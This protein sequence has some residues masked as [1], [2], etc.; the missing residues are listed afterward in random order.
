MGCRLIWETNLYFML[1]SFILPLPHLMFHTT[2]QLP[3]FLQFTCSDEA[4]NYTNNTTFK[5]NLDTVL[6]SI[7]SKTSYIDYGYYN[8]TA[9][10]E[11]DRATALAL[12]RG[13]VE[14]EQCRRCV[15]NSTLRIT[16]DCPNQKE[17]EGLYQDCQIRYSNNS[18]YGVKDNTVQLFLVNG[19]RVEDW[20]GFNMALRSLFDRLKM[21]ASS[22]SSIQKSAWG[23]EKVRSPSMDTIYGLVDCFP[24]LSYLDCFDC[25]NQL[26]A[27]LPSCCNASIG[28][29]LAATSCQ[30]AYEL[31]PVYAP[32]P[33][34]PSPL[35]LSPSPS[36]ENNDNSGRSRTTFVIIMVTI[37]SA[38]VILLVVIFT[39]LILRKKK[40]KR[41]SDNFEG[42]GNE[43]ISVETIQFDFDSIKVATND[44][45]SEN[46][47]GQ[48]GFGV[49]YKGKLP[50]GR[51]IAVKRLASSSQQGDV[52]FKNEVLLMLKLQ[53][54]NLVRLLGFCL[55]GSE[56][57]LIYEF[58]QN[59]SLDHFIFDSAKR[60]LLDWET[61]C[62][63]INGIARGLVYLHEDSQHRI[64]HR[65]LKA[66]NI[67]LDED[68]NSKISDFGMARLFEVDQTQGNTNRVV[69]TYGYMAPEYVIHG[70]FSVKSDVYSFGILVLEILSG[71][72]NNSFHNKELSE[73]L[74]SFAWTNWMA[75]TI[76]NII[77]STLTVG[78][79]I[80][81]IRCIHIGLLC[82]QE[83]L[84]NRP[85]M[86][87]VVM[88]L[89]T[90][91][92]TLPM[93]SKPAF[94]LHSSTNRYNGT[95]ARP[96]GANCENAS[97][98]LSKNY[99][100]ITEVKVIEMGSLCCE[101][102]FFL[103][104]FILLL[105][106]QHSMF[107]TTNSQPDFI[108]SS[109]S[110][111]AIYTNNSPFKKNLHNV[112]FSISSQTTLLDYGRFYNATS[113]EDPDRAT[114][115]AL[116]RGGVPLE[117]C[118]SCVYNST[119]RITK[120]CPKQREAEGWYSDCQI[121]YSNNSIYGVLVRNIKY[122]VW[123]RRTAVNPDGF[124]KVLRSLL[125]ELGREAASGSSVQKSA[126]GD[127]KVPSSSVDIIYGLVDCLPDL[128][129]LDCL[130]CLHMLQK[131][132]PTCCNNSM[133]VR[134][135]GISCQ[136]NY[137]SKPIYPSL[138]S[139]PSLPP[140]P[141]P[142]SPPTPVISGSTGRS[143]SSVV[144]VVVAVVPTVIL[145]VAIFIILILRKRK[146]KRPLDNFER[147]SLEDTTDEI[148]CVEMIQFDLDSIKAATNNFAS[149]NKL[150]QGGFG[151]VY[152][153]RLAV[154]RPIAVKR[155][156]NNSQQ[157]DAEFKN[158]VLLVLK[159]QH[160][161]LVRLLGFCLQGSERLL[162]YEFIP[163]GSLDNFIFDPQK[164]TQLNWERRYKII[165]GIARGLLYLHE[166][167]RFRIIH[168]D[169]KASNILLDQEMNPKIGDFGM[170]RLF[171]VDQ[172]RG[173]TNR[174]VGTFGYMAP[175][176]VKHGHFSVK[177]DVFSFGILV[178]EILSGKKNNNSHNGEHSEDLSSFVWTN[179]RAGTTTNV[180][181]S[182]L[183]VG[184]RMDME[185]CIHIGLLC[186]Q[187]NLVD[188]PTMNSIV[189]MLSS[190]TLTL[191]I[192]HK[193][194]FFL[195]SM[196]TNNHIVSRSDGNGR[197]NPSI[198]PSINNLSITEIHAR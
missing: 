67:L 64:I 183:T 123:N 84:T 142:S 198:Q 114:A 173:N 170:A 152:K 47:L 189:T 137:E 53:H 156:A 87:T 195:H 7:S 177:S 27:S 119:L 41:P 105:V 181:D 158:E 140:S 111:N 56:R 6:L 171:E 194:A 95:L 14:L 186:I 94:F 69:G 127:K 151:V 54:R 125:D 30:L 104:S 80:E 59:G 192:P 75:G 52:E 164:R 108:Y 31:H 134:V 4:G 51:A 121:R 179:W 70:R 118:R 191:P 130:D 132:L 129:Y 176:Y 145:L 168:R 11:P 159:L 92:L 58:I 62:K 10:Q 162:I 93:P 91:S 136:L 90:S 155:L 74:S 79:R 5:K 24:D 71:Q 33:P 60:G 78:S 154:G 106:L 65:D 28:V 68:M 20:V 128:S 103:V 126:W 46:K 153:G 172:T 143:R 135:I 1:Y 57:L 139:S 49:V 117:Q 66:S 160:R 141:L 40:R 167:S 97:I 76:S 88:M 110:N 15:Y 37:V 9:G 18:I 190:S 23:G 113:G 99:I 12:C 169:L 196:S 182:T 174:I 72:K 149:E 166:D 146:H 32:L 77:D 3:P 165:N 35:S 29:R 187:E 185:R 102:P 85:T 101:T 89:S 73:D 25:L 2:S 133:G 180:I 81:M 148:S 109:C 39:I 115:L 86:T 178:L 122:V 100:P 17:A 16:Q 38:A 50:D 44:F 193:P 184:S 138:I 197:E 63:I 45:A 13:G 98:Q 147:A 144:V 157:G 34:P 96:G 163:N 48:G 36:H 22:G 83:N 26:Q 120:D 116:C 150:G 21:E 82:V 43:I 42:T 8:E 61:R 112:L 188:R 161:N 131:F 175:E 124:N 107:P 19:G 55:Q